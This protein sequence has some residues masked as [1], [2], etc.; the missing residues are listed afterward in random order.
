[1]LALQGSFCFVFGM[2][3]N[4]LQTEKAWIEQ[5]RKKKSLRKKKS[6]IPVPYNISNIANSQRV[7]P[8]QT[9]LNTLQ[10]TSHAYEN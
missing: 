1:M 3:K 10:F 7:F 2:A 9:I 8:A 5:E 6:R 4:D